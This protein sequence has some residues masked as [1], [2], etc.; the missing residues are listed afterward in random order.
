M[1]NRRFVLYGPVSQSML[2]LNGKILYHDSREE[3]E[4]L[5]PG[6]EVREMPGVVREADC[7]WIGHHPQY[8]HVTFPID[9][10]Q[11]KGEIN[12]QQERWESEADGRSPAPPS[13]VQFRAAG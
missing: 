11:F 4:F 3:L 8:K 2:T 12:G 9:R 1:S 7:L 6:A 10:S 13:F 5:L